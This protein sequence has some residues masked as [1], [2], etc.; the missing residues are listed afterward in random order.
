MTAICF[1]RGCEMEVNIVGFALEF[2]RESFPRKMSPQ[3][4]FQLRRFRDP[5]HLS[6]HSS[7]NSVRGASQK[8]DD[9]ERGEQIDRHGSKPFVSVLGHDFGRVDDLA[10]LV[11]R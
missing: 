10:S 7:P 9:D 11:R 5:Q 4:L 8:L 2:D 1:H 6:E 3:I